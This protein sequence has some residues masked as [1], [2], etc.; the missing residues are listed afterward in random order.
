MEIIALRAGP[1]DALGLLLLLLRLNEMN[2]HR[3]LLAIGA[4]SAF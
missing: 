3:R 2:G 4:R 1:L